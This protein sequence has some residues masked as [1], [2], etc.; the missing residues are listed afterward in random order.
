VENGTKKEGVERDE[1]QNNKHMTKLPEK[2][3]KEVIGKGESKSPTNRRIPF[4]LS[5]WKN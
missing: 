5:C 1:K 3:C 4:L 2:P